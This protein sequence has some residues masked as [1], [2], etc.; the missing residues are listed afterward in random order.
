MR[1]LIFVCL[2]AVPTFAAEPTH[3]VTPADYASVSAIT[4]IAVSPDGKHVA[5]ALATW[6]KAEDNRKSDVWIVRADGLGKPARVTFD[7]ANDRNLKWAGNKQIHFLSNR[8]KPG[9]TKAPYDGTS[10]VWQVK[11]TM[12][13]GEIGGEFFQESSEPRAVTKVEG[14]VTGFDYS[15]EGSLF[16]TLDKN[17]SDEDEFAKLRAKYDKVEYGHGVRKVSELHKLDLST[18]RTE[19][20]IGET[21]YIRSFAATRDGKKIAMVSAFDDTVVKSE[22][23]SRVDVWEAGKVVTPPTDAYRKNSKNSPYAWLENLCWNSNGTRFAF[24]AVHDAFPSEVIVGSVE[25]EKW[26]TN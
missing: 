2:L 13:K 21:R 9:E 4:E 1:S 24:T 16:Y 5:Y 22:G 12:V 15:E 14:G 6:D 18:W 7:R 26:S 8:K 11:L 10:Q 20:L 25:S 19:K 3:T 17:H 23:E